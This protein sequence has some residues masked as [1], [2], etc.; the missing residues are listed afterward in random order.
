MDRDPVPSDDQPEVPDDARLGALIRTV[1]DD[2]RC[3]PPRL[4]ATTWRARVALDRASPGAGRHRW[5]GRMAGAATLAVA[6]TVVL[7]MSAVYLSSQPDRGAAGAS[8][9]AA[10]SA[11]SAPG[12]SRSTATASQRPALVRSGAFPSV[13][14]VLLQGSGGFRFADLTTGT[15][16]PNLPWGDGSADTVLA[17]P[18]GGWVCICVT[19]RGGN[20]GS[21]TSL[22]IA[23]ET[24]DASGKSDGHVDLET[25]SSEADA[26]TLVT[27]DST[28]VD[29]RAQASPDGRFA[30]LGRSNRTATGWRAGVDVVDLTTLRVIDTIAL[31]DVDHADRADGRSWVR[32]A[33][34]VSLRPGGNAHVIASD[35]YVDDA[36]TAVP[37]WGT[38]RWSTNTSGNS[39]PVAINQ[40]TDPAGAACNAWEQGLI[41]DTSYFV[42][43]ISQSGEARVDRYRLDGRAIGSDAIGR[44]SGGFEVVSVRSGSRLFLWDASASTLVRYDLATGRSDRL[45]VSGTARVGGPDDPVGAIGRAL[46]AWLAPAAQAKALLQPGIALSPDGRTLYALGVRGGASEASGST[47]IFTFDIGEGPLSL[48]SRWEPTA[49]FISLAV[50]EDGAFVYATGMGGVDAQGNE[51]AVSPSVTVFDATDGSVRLMAGHLAGN[52]LLFVEPTVR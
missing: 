48:K 41:D 16:G 29:I 17:R 15:L 20:G 35:W 13:T 19:S 49:D 21:P 42:A 40:A 32:L 50:S 11:S 33:P 45:T 2:W 27:P 38:D 34:T 18:G 47:G 3:G 26:T 4:G 43:C 9:S 10:G 44:W 28:R 8:P 23:L 12:P 36:T 1:A 30:Y 31:P 52:E 6:A 24:V 25:V 22:V 5:I 46:G 51:A 14:S 37:P 39:A 7:A